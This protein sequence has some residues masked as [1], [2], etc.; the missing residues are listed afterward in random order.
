MSVLPPLIRI[1]YTT[2]GSV[3]GGYDILRKI[4]RMTRTPESPIAQHI[5]NQT[6]TIPRFC[7]PSSAARPQKCD[8][9]ILGHPEALPPVSETVLVVK[10][11]FSH[12]AKRTIY[13][14][15]VAT[16]WCGGGGSAGGESCDPLTQSP[17][18]RRFAVPGN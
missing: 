2:P 12:F 9:D 8:G 15:G 17:I 4:K 13:A 5:H 11:A 18:P 1:A 7:R 10:A 16:V 6:R 3:G 14:V